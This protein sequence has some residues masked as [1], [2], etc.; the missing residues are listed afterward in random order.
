MVFRPDFELDAP[1]FDSLN[2]QKWGW[3][4]NI[5]VVDSLSLSGIIELRRKHPK[6]GLA[7]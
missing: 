7:E 1:E 2:D 3:A 6:W 4:G 5:D